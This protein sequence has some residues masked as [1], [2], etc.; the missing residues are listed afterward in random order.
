MHPISRQS[1]EQIFYPYVSI[2]S[3]SGTSAENLA[4]AYVH[5]FFAALP[6]FAAH[7]Q[8]FG[9][10]P[11]AEDPHGRSVA[12]GLVRGQGPR[13]VVLLHHLDVV[14]IEDFGPL[15][16]LA[17]QPQ[18]LEQ[19][20]RQNADGL[21]PQARDDLLSGEYLFGRGTADMK[22]GGA[23]ELAIMQAAS[24]EAELAGNLLLLAV[25]DEENLSAGAR[26]AAALMA[27]LKARY[28]LEYV[29]MINAEPH[30]RKQPGVGVLSG[31]SI[32]KIMPFVYVRGILAHAGK[33]PEGFNP[34]GVLGDV[35][36]RTEMS[37]EFTEVQ[38]AVGEMTPPP[39]W[40]MLRDSKA[41]Y[42][43]SMPLSAFGCLSVLTLTN[44]PQ[45]ILH[46]LQEVCRLAAAEASA[47]ANRAADAFHQATNRPRR[48][49]AWQA[50][51]RT[52]EQFLSRQPANEGFEALYQEANGQMLAALQ[53]GEQSTAAA[54]WAF[55]DRL[56][57]AAG[58][59]Q[60]L[61]IVGFLPPF[62]PSVSYL[63]RPEYT[64]FIQRLW[65]T[66]DAFSQ[67]HWGEPYELEAYFTGI[68]DLSYSS[69]NGAQQVEQAIARNMP[70]Y[71]GY[72]SVPFQQ[73]SEISMPCLNIGPWGKDFHKLTE[74][75]HQ[76]DLF[77]RTPQ[78]ILLAIREAL[79]TDFRERI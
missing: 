33:S 3:A 1:I 79:S 13:T 23:I 16:E 71:G 8:Q 52:F 65:H 47:Q 9:A 30:Q 60:P 72:Y 67:A 58:E 21:P 36:R 61:V 63:D 12:W 53:R 6:Y 15:K 69:L 76:A 26:A 46:Q 51:V 34:L 64:T 24:Q 18:A 4:A 75:V 25:P 50:Q 7:P 55:L 11:V 10:Q 56:T 73:I 5:Q 59:H 38:A 14:E 19:A 35:V 39:T 32:G 20:L 66:L 49:Q 42:D 17:F 54:T 2:N 28:G 45:A 41:V 44:R 22:G 43:V 29:L 70:L 78:L 40:L 77:E 31:G 27:E 74:R 48:S 68:S 37:L 57:Q 62:Y